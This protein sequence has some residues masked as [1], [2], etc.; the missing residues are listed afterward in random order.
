MYEELSNEGEPLEILLTRLRNHAIISTL[1]SALLNCERAKKLDNLS[2]EEL[3]LI[4]RIEE[5]STYVKW[6]IDNADP[7]FTSVQVLNNCNSWLSASVNELNNFINNRNIQH[8]RNMQGNLDAVVTQ[9]PVLLP[10]SRISPDELP[11]FKEAIVSFRRSLATHLANAK[12]EV[13]ELHGKISE[14]EQQL[15]QLRNQITAERNRV[16]S[17]ANEARTQLNAFQ[18]Q[19]SQAQHERLTQFNN[20][21]KDRSQRFQNSMDQW[22]ERVSNALQRYNDEFN[23]AFSNWRVDG[24]KVKQDF[25][26]LAED[27]LTK[28]SDYKTQVETIVGIISNTAQAGAYKKIANEERATMWFWQVIAVASMICIAG[29]GIYFVFESPPANSITW[30]YL[31]KRL[32]V[33][34]ALGGLATYAAQ[35]SS[36]HRKEARRNRKMQLELA[37]IEPFL[38]SLPK[39]V[40]DKVKEGLAQK[41]FG[42]TEVAASEES[43]TTPAIGIY[44]EMGNKLVQAI[45]DSIQKK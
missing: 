13:E 34:L 30:L 26:S 20:E 45:I 31:S 40:Q 37:S 36:N 41:F 24:E 11:A 23:N 15:A 9:I 27:T 3:E 28:L 6:A 17:I 2:V 35:Q 19:F 8:L 14:V 44:G 43:G 18:Q 38:A 12:Q 16:D 32:I 33:T 22:N 29:L 42:N 5:I 39:D 10:T 21:A 1:N 7:F 25:V 4:Q